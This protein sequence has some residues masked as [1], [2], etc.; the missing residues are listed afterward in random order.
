MDLWVVECFTVTDD[1]EKCDS[2]IDSVWDSPEKADARAKELKEIV[3]NF[4]A[5]IRTYLLLNQNPITSFQ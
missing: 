1:D 3:P 4:F 5:V 2:N